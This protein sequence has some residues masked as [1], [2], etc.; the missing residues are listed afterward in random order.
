VLATFGHDDPRRRQR[1]YGLG[2]ARIAPLGAAPPWAP[3]ADA[4][5]ALRLG[6]DA[7][8]RLHRAERR[9]VADALGAVALED[10]RVGAEEAE[11]VR[12]AC[13]LMG[14]SVPPLGDDA[15]GSGSLDVHSLLASAR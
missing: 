8:S 9:P 11:I 6:F 10:A 14:V 12:T 15:S 3:P 7:A 13:L 4:L 5:A 1:A 2:I